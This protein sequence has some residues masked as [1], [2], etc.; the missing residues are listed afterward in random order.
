MVG[1]LVEAVQFLTR[2]RRPRR[3]IGFC[4]LLAL[5]ACGTF[6]D[7][8]V[9]G[10]Y[11]SEDTAPPGVLERVRRMDILPRSV[12]P[13]QPDQGASGGA[14]SKPMV[15]PGADTASMG[16]VT[17]APPGAK[18]N[19]NG[20]GNGEGYDLN[21]ENTPVATVAK[22]ILGDILNIG[23]TIDP[24][25]QGTVSLASGR[26]ISRSDIL[27]VLENALR[28]SAVALVRDQTGYRLVPAADAVGGAPVD[29]P[30][31]TEPGYGISVVPL[32]F[33]SAQT[34]IKLL[35]NFA[36]KPGSGRADPNRN[37]L[38]I[39]GSGSERRT[40][41]DT[42][43]SFDADWMRGQSVGVFPVRNSAP[44]PIVAELERIMDAGEGGLGKDLVKFLPVAR[45]NAIMVV[46]RKPDLLKTAGNWIHRL[47]QSDTAAV[48]L[49]VYQV[50]Y[51]NARQIAALLND[52]FVGRGGTGLDS[53]TNQIAPGAG[54][55]SASSTA[56]GGT[57][58][59]GGLGGTA[60][61]LGGT[62]GGL[63]AAGGAATPIAGGSFPAGGAAG[64][65]GGGFSGSGFGGQSSRNFSIAGGT[66]PNII[67]PNAPGGGLGGT[68]PVGPAG[69]G[70]MPGV[71][72]TPDVINN[73]IL[74]YASQENYRIIEKTLRQV[75][76]PQLQVAVD[77]TIA[78]ITLNDNLNY[79]VQFFLQSR[80]L[81]LP[82]D[83]GSLLNTTAG[84]GPAA[85]TTPTTTTSTT[86]TAASVIGAASA[87]ANAA[88]GT[89][90]NRAFP[91][92]NFLIGAEAQPNVILDALHQI[93]DVNILSNPS[94]VV[95][96][97]QAV[98]LQ[99]GDQVP[100][101]TGS[102]TVLTAGTP[103]VNSIDYRNTGI[104][105]RVVPRINLNGNIV[106]DIEQEISNVAGGIG[107]NTLT[108]TVSQR[109]VK[110]SISVASGQTVLLA[111]LVS[112]T[113]NRTKDGIPFLDQI[114]GLGVAFSHTNNTK[115]RTELIMF[116]RPQIIRDSLDAH[117]VAE[118][119]RTKMGG[120]VV[121][122]P[123][124]G[125]VR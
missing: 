72:I 78:E 30:S 89:F 43:L 63:G 8:P 57:G 81:G 99:V 85:T 117:A 75:D 62:A 100:V 106:L 53:A 114:P 2:R 108:P 121:G 13:P 107:S 109:R 27:F 73:T 17:V 68:G 59:A 29:P 34:A 36:L 39:Q 3:G 19:G 45:M 79:G 102:A 88:A 26:P 54:V 118:E 90:I 33:V 61:G 101:S 42:I 74:I 113:S 4:C 104:I 24:R 55:T 122:D 35:D 65:A 77:A 87:V 94:V 41:I 120:R 25:V 71:R 98:T 11:H 91:G 31:R 125:S 20:N 60:G 28:M 44:D 15:F 84:A 38:I 112:Q 86:T 105:L 9:P 56:A 1:W 70:I 69:P 80:N 49:K 110:S 96:N 40:A 46:S 103:I 32:R 83:R 37:L 22:V 119:L 5:G 47:D 7:A 51:G 50:R 64:G 76:R 115:T 111:G 82:A 18:A 14:S 92:F 123:F 58:A 48:N 95:L 52:I 66:N 21:F 93:T 116:I 67:D 97:N 10:P 124:P 6:T 12:Q 23:Y 16:S